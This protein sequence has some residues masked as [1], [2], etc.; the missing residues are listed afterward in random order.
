MPTPPPLPPLARDIRAPA[1]RVRVVDVDEARQRLTSL[2]RTDRVSLDVRGK[3]EWVVQPRLL[4]PVRAL[5]AQVNG[6]LVLDGLPTAYLV[7]LWLRGSVHA[8]AGGEQRE[9]TPGRHG[10]LLSPGV[11]LTLQY[12]GAEAMYENFS[13]EI[14]AEF[15]RAAL[16]SLVGRS[17]DAPPVFAPGLSLAREPLASV[18]RLLHLFHAEAER[19]VGLLRGP[20]LATT[21]CDVIARALLTGV[22]HSH[23]HLV[24]APAPDAGSRAV[25]RAS[26]YMTAH[27]DAAL[28]M[29]DVARVAGTSVRVLQ[30]GF[31]SQLRTT[32]MAFLRGRRLELARRRLLAA[33]SGASVTVIAHDCGFLHMGRFSTEYR[34]RFGESPRETL[35]RGQQGMPATGRRA[36]RR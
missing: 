24:S 5:R 36:V 10:V 35:R 6:R 18:A 25:S 31:R 34:K 14:D 27:A 26:Q 7:L 33:P 3:F 4:G 30:A 15:L 29:G 8:T 21:L 17:I 23:S 1:S 11:P 2:Y 20:L 9:A 28:S 16:E 13:T 22:E 32:P 19:E 12:T